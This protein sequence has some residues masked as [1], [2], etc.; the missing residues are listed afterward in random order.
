MGKHTLGPINHR[1]PASRHFPAGQLSDIM[2]MVVV[3]RP[4]PKPKKRPAAAGLFLS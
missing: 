1:R 2:D 4:S 3:D